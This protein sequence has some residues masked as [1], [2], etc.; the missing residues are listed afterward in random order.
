MA[1]KREAWPAITYDTREQRPWDFRGDV[2]ARLGVTAAVSRGTLD[3]GDYALV[4]AP[5]YARIERKS[6]GDFVGSVTRD[7]PRFMR[8]MKRL[9][10]YRVRAVIVEADLA[11][12]VRET[13]QAAPHAVVASALKVMTDFGVPVV[14]ANCRAWAEWQCAWILRRVWEKRVIQAGVDDLDWSDG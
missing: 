2:C 11:M 3:T 4:E 14:W 1:S 12:V 8:E 7:H 5:E 6:L 13:R 9:A 10:D